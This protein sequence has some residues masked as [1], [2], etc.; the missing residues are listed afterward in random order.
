MTDRDRLYALYLSKTIAEKGS[1]EIA[2][3]APTPALSRFL[4]SLPGVTLRTSD[5]YMPGVDD[6]LDL[7]DLDKYAD[8]SFDIFICSHMLEHVP[9]DIKAMRELFRITKRG[10]LGVAMVPIMKG[11]E[12]THE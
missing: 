3:F 10:G 9:D 5:L 8:E 2:E 1:V 4:R 12:A 11:V 6:K 7:Q